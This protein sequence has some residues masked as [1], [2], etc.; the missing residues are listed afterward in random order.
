MLTLAFA[1]TAQA[2]GPAQSQQSPLL[3]LLPIVLIFVIFYF[4]LIRPQKK[5][6]KEHAQMLGAL[7][8]NDDVVTSG[9]IYGTIV[10]IQDDVV[11]LR[12]DDNT[13]IKVQKG[14]IGR[15]KKTKTEVVK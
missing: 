9:G 2:A 3:S 11:T 6:Q 14:S 13:R 12:I 1:Q 4:L 10:N 15:L 7:A 8:K 5:N